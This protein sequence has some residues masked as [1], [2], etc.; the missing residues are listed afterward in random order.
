MAGKGPEPSAAG[1][2][3][4]LWR[5]AGDLPRL[6]WHLG[7]RHV[8]CAFRPGA[9]LVRRGAVPKALLESLGATVT[10]ETGVFDPEPMGAAGHVTH[11]SFRHHLSEE[12][13]DEGDSP[14]PL[15]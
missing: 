13:P 8:A 15:R 5:I 4:A 10:P 6:A 7:L 9:L 2:E 11:H 14:E 3:E 1:G 12:E